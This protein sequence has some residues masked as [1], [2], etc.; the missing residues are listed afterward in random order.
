MSGTSNLITAA[1][2]TVTLAVTSLYPSPITL[3]NFGTDRA[4]EGEAVEFAETA[5]S[6]DGTLN[7][8]YVPNPFRQTYTLSPASSFWVPLETVLTAIQTYRATYRWTG[9]VI[10]PSTGRKY[11]LN[12]GVLKT[13]TPMPNAA[14]V[15]EARTF[16]IEWQSSIASPA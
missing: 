10:L 7:A 13:A 16:V 6:V 15:L 12:A 4:F 5:M 14:R 9:V 8:G 1:D 2:A 3:T 11:T